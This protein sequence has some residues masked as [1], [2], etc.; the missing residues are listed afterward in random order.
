[1]SE[2]ILIVTRHDGII[3]WLARRGIVGEIKQRVKAND[4]VGKE[5]YGRLP[6][7]MAALASK[8]YTISIP[9]PTAEFRLDGQNASAD[10]M[11]DMGAHLECY[12]IE[13]IQDL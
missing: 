2:E 6:M 3:D 12:I 4:V 5:V 10:D 8:Y 11:E 13:R 7:Y 9:Y 1:M